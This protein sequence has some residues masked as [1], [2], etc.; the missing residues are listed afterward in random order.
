MLYIKNGIV[1]DPKTKTMK[2]QQLLIEDERIVSIADATDTEAV[3]ALEEKAEHNHATILDAEGLYIGPGLVDVHVHFRDPGFT[4]KEDIETGAKAAAKG[5]FTTVVLMANTK[6]VVDNVDTLKYVL[7]KGSTTD[8]HVESCATITCG[9]QGKELTDMAAL[10][11]NGAAGFTD[12]GIP[13]MDEEVVRSAMKQ[14]VT[15]QEQFARP[16]PLSF[17]EE[18]AQYITNNGINRGEASDYYRIGGSDRQAEISMVERDLQIA[19]ETGAC[20]DVQHISTK[21]AVE[22]VRKAKKVSSGNIHAE[23]T[24][25]HIMLTEKAAIEHGTLAKMNP[26]LRTEE[27]R[28]A[29]IAGVMD[30]TIDLIATDH[31][32]HAAEEKNQDITKAPSGIIGLE[33]SF[34]CAVTELV[35][36]NNMQ[37]VELFDRMSYAPAMMYGYDRGYIAAGA[38]ADLVIFNPDE[39]VV[40]HTFLSKS[41]N[42]PFKGQA[43]KGKIKTTICKGKIIYQ[44]K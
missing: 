9:M 31:A 39:D 41:D 6:P 44:D 38:M 14:A 29:V 30:G 43:L 21:E 12:D 32:P 15:L 11:Q 3:N 18:N 10:L 20:F 24:P 27:D 40:Y 7:D 28:Q 19:L 36:A 35:H 33:T 5:G 42:T 25:H 2:K 13:I 8:I 22:L 34:S 37:L 17:H 1:I 23:A 16:I 4:H 26:P